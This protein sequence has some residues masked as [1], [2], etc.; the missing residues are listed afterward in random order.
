ME[1]C[2]E[3]HMKRI[4]VTNDD[5]IDAEGIKLLGKTL[6][7]MGEL[8]VIAPVEEQSGSSHSLTIGRPVRIE[9]RDS[10]HIGIAGTPTDC[11]LLAHHSLMKSGIDL[12]VSGINHGYNLA[13]DVLY[14]GTVAAAMEGR[15]LGYPAIGIS[16]ARDH[17]TIGHES[18][19]FI[20]SYC[21]MVLDRGQPSLTSINLPEGEP[22][23]IRATRLGKRVYKDVVNRSKDANGEW[24]LILSGE[25]SSIP[26]EGAD[27]EAV[28]SGL[29]SVTPLHLDLT[30]FDGMDELN[31]DLKKLINER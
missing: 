16:A 8:F 7:D 15:L 2:L 11:V 31:E 29:I 14:S 3:F 12:V 6:D 30:S 4:L 27:T 24:H 26:I 21:G 19:G 1:F 23:G 13:D 20:R 28:A 10:H 18:L 22:A 9:E 25:L 17:S 5:G